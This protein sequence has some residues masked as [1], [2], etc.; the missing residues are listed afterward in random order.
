MVARTAGA[1]EV[2]FRIASSA[3]H[4]FVLLTA[5]IRRTR[6]ICSPTSTILK[7]CRQLHQG[8]FRLPSCRSAGLLYRAVGE[9][10]RN[11]RGAAILRRPCFS[12][13]YPIEPADVGEFPAGQLSLLSETGLIFCRPYCACDRRLARHRPR[14]PR[15]PRSPKAGAHIV[16]VARTVGGLEELDDDIKAAGRHRHAGAARSERFPPAIDRMGAALFRALGQGSMRCS[17]MAGN[18]GTR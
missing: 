11:A 3:D 9:A 6:K 7:A 2:H 12:G 15:A 5:S 4:A 14:H 1:T 13:D 8:G 18:S 17:A 10:K 16:A